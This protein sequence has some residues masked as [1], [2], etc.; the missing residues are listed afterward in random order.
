MSTRSPNDDSFPR[1][2]AVELV[3]RLP[4]YAKLALAVGRDE[5]LPGPRRTAL[6]AAGTY[7]VS[8]VGLVPGFV[9]L[10]GQLD[11]MW[12]LLKALRYALDGLSPQKKATH[13]AE[14]DVTEVQMEEDMAAVSQLAA[15]SARR[16]RSTAVR[17]AA[18]G[19]RFGRR[20]SRGATRIRTDVARRVTELLDSGQG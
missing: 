5:A 13:L 7:V 6:I 9:P 2:Q 19:R 12:V 8:P 11:D 15:W 20:L 14:A 1:E 18:G 17:A 16:G 3:K 4:A 10:L